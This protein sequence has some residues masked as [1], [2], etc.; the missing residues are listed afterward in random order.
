[1]AISQKNLVH[2]LGVTTF[3]W[4]VHNQVKLYI[5]GESFF[6]AML[7]A[8]LN[9]KHYV[10]LEMY[11]VES[12]TV[13]S[14]FIQT[15]TEV[16]ERGV[17]VFLLFDGFGSSG[18]KSTDRDKLKHENISLVFYNP[19]NY[20]SLRRNLFRDHRKILVVD[21][22]SAFIG[23]AGITD[24]F[25][26]T[27]VDI[28]WRETMLEVNGECVCDW[29][30]AF[31]RSWS[32]YTSVPLPE[33]EDVRK[34]TTSVVP[35]RISCSVG[36]SRF[37]IKRS[38]IKRI[39]S[40]ERTIWISTAY[41]VPSMKVRRALVRAAK[42][43]VDVKLLLPGSKSDHP[44]IRH[45]GRR[46]YYRLLK[47]SIEIYE[48][49]PRFL[50]QKVLLCDSW[51]SIGSSNIDRWNFRWNLEAN[52]EVENQ[53]FVDEITEMFNNDF[54]ESEKI[55]LD[56]WQKRPWYYRLQEWFWGKM[57]RIIDRV[58]H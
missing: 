21:N 53:L 15:L 12:G 19:L 27:K 57:D 9:A 10:M 8:I 7:S 13:A 42:R 41:F 34:I 23:G 3:P 49:Q 16:A 30:K 52:Q 45:A 11:L 50:H 51:V 58:L 46:F 20:G 26:T 18:F 32:S 54:V 6:P 24:A 44:A 2:S 35:C 36:S 5:N 43:G 38:L 17:K 31:S 40:A 33:C 55:E 14:R 28:G 29:A 37:G 39:R 48:Y 56:G 1:M 25:I 4:R 22:N 47:A